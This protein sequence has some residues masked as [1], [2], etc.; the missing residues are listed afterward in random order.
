MA[1]AADRK[2]SWLFV[3]FNTTLFF[4]FV[5]SFG[6]LTNA[7]KSHAGATY[8]LQAAQFSDFLLSSVFLQ[9]SHI[10]GTF[11]FISPYIP[12]GRL[13]SCE[14]FNPGQIS[15]Q[16]HNTL[17]G[18]CRL[19]TV[20]LYMGNYHLMNTGRLPLWRAFRCEKANL[21]ICTSPVSHT[22]KQTFRFPVLFNPYKSNG[23]KSKS[24]A[25]DYLK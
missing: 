12:A 14:Q 10:Q 22:P 9:F 17:P 2:I 19:F 7:I 5:R 1:A 21:R 18:F 4:T 11:H 20:F 15:H 13:L 3:R 24:P 16:F 23:F 8:P 25:S 6:T